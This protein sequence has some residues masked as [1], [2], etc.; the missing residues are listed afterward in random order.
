MP[1]AVTT[2]V[3]RS[4]LLLFV[5]AGCA[6]PAPAPASPPTP[7]YAASV[8]AA[9][10]RMHLRYAAAL[11]LEAAV[12]L[13]D[14]ARVRVDAR[15]IDVLVEP[16]AVGQARQMA[17]SVR[18]AA[19]RVAIADSP[20]TAGERAA[21]MGRA[22]GRC[23]EATH[24]TV[25]FLEPTSPP[26][27]DLMRQHQRAGLQMW[28]GLIAPDDRLWR[29]GATGLSAMPSSLLANVA[30]RS[31]SDDLDDVTRI[32]RD[33]HRALDTQDQDT[34]ATL[35]GQILGSCAHCHAALRDL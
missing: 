14:L 15:M 23:H 32:E 7:T 21:T 20:A 3:T 11:D 24:A 1:C 22:C 30:T 31:S 35:F 13:G 25:T 4:L 6:R 19:H 29:T 2:G 26:P 8:K 16:G 34:R 28:E 17:E 27:D 12:A 18:N 33:A 10:D 9:M 5:F